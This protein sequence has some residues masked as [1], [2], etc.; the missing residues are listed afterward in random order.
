MLSHHWGDQLSGGYN[1]ARFLHLHDSQNTTLVAR[2][3]L[4]S[5]D[6]MSP[7]HGRAISKRLESEIA[8]MDYIERF[9]N[10]PVPR[11][12]LHSDHSEQQVRSPYL[13]MSKV[14]G[15]PLVKLWDKMDD[16]KRLV[17]LRQVID[18]ILELWSH[19]FDKTGALFRRPEVGDGRTD[20]GRFLNTMSYRHAA[21]YWLA[22]ANAKIQSIRDEWFGNKDQLENAA[23][24]FMRSL[25]PALYDPSID[26]QLEGFPLNHGDFHSQNIM[27]AT[28][29]LFAQYPLFIVDHPYWKDDNPLRE[30]NVRDQAT[31][32]QLIRE[33]E[34]K[35]KAVMT[36][37]LWMFSP[38]YPLL[39]KFVFGDDTE[40]SDDD[41]ESSDEE[42]FSFSTGYYW[43][44]R[45][46]G[47]LRKDEEALEKDHLVWLE[48]RDVLGEAEVGN[49]ME[50]AEFKELVS[51]HAD[52]FA[53]GG[54]VCSWLESQ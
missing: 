35:R 54:K 40:D 25:I 53:E 33:G 6:A 4:R 28:P 18:I 15:V 27:I 48:A 5:E 32:D 30:R 11:V 29:T 21:E 7:T 22:Y 45:T 2:V 20:P 39:F 17:V 41:D 47:I 12:Y 34:Q 26:A 42:K 51:R 52:S 16:D 3:P 10:I 38:V 1:L 8:T 23:F 14:E 50:R 49:R 43:A 36:N 13:L 37:T 24:W 31:F 46:K 9:T 44:L 19:R